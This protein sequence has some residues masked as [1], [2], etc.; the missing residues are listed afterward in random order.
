MT[1]DGLEDYIGDFKNKE[2]RF[3]PVTIQDVNKKKYY[4]AMVK[5]EE[6]SIFLFKDKADLDAYAEKQNAINLSK[7]KHLDALDDL[8][9]LQSI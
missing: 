5:D 2:I 7:V 9:F 4:I 6:D 8:G 1:D 3:N